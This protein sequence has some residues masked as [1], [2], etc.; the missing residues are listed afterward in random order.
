[1]VPVLRRLLVLGI[2]PVAAS[3]CIL[4]V[5]F[6][7]MNPS[8]HDLALRVDRSAIGPKRWLEVSAR[9]QEDS[10]VRRV[11]I[12]GGT[13]LPDGCRLDL[14]LAF[15]DHAAWKEAAAVEGGAFRAVADVG[16]RALH[17]RT[18]VAEAVFLLENQGEEVMQSMH[19]QP[20][21]LR[22][23]DWLTIPRAGTGPLGEEALQDAL[24]GCWRLLW[25]IYR[26]EIRGQSTIDIE[27]VRGTAGRVR[28]H[29]KELRERVL[30][31][32]LVEAL[33]KAEVLC[34]EC[35]ATARSLASMG[36][37]ER[38][39]TERRFE[40]RLIKSPVTGAF[41]GGAALHGQATTF[42]PEG[43][44]E[45]RCERLALG[46]LCGETAAGS[47]GAGRTLDGLRREGVPWAGAD[48]SSISARLRRSGPWR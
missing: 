34:R 45:E 47:Q 31:S 30:A 1:M 37:M 19:F 27:V 6:H 14:E 41:S 20:N 38:E 15:R 48:T 42:P 13:N 22:A 33:D 29:L 11:L 5:Y 39:R 40:E 7:W 9:Y 21:R 43:E 24:E 26:N 36:R 44:R 46:L 35:A 4:F 23:W 32:P 10:S 17:P 18:H 3:F 16:R 2:L 25:K 8:S 12:S 28:D